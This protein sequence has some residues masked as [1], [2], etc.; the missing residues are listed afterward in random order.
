MLRV[1][2]LNRTAICFLYLLIVIQLTGASTQN[3]LISSCTALIFKSE[4]HS[5]SFAFTQLFNRKYGITYQNKHIISYYTLIR[6]N[7]HEINFLHGQC[8]YKKVE[9]KSQF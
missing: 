5:I 7:F 9:M 4:S 2:N 3:A 8:C 6:K 1:L